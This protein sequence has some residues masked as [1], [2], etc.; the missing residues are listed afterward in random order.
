MGDE[1]MAQQ[2]LEFCHDHGMEDIF[3]RVTQMSLAALDLLQHIRMGEDPN[4]LA[5]LVKL[6][7]RVTADSRYGGRVA[8]EL[9]FEPYA[10]KRMFEIE[11]QQVDPN[12]Y[13][14]IW[15]KSLANGENVS[16]RDEKEF[17]RRRRIQLPDSEMRRL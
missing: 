12:R 2:F 13:R 14:G 9:V 11:E 15:G 17:Y 3:E 4:L 16:F 7:R 6:T 1:L 8:L 10:N 5:M